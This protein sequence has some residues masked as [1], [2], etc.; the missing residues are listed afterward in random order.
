MTGFVHTTLAEQFK[1]AVLY[2][3]HRF[4][5]TSVPGGKIEGSLDAGSEY[6]KAFTV[7]QTMKDFVQIINEHKEKYGFG[8]PVIAFGGSYG[9]MLSA[10]LRM[11]YPN[12]VWGALAAS[13]PVRWFRE[14]IDPGLYAY[15]SG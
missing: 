14:T 2:V 3:E 10:W 15:T 13:A 7:E 11:K 6:R 1:A 9:G 5:G 12:H 8:G 4:Y